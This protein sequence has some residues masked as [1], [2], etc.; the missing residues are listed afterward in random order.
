MSYATPEDLTQ[1]GL[2]A[3][4]LERF[5]WE[6]QQAALEAA[7]ATVEGYLRCKYQVPLVQWGL[8]IRRVVCVLAAY[9]LM[10]TLG[11]NPEGSDTHLRLRTEDALRWLK[12]VSEGVVTLQ[13]DSH[14]A[15]PVP[16]VQSGRL[17]GW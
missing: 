13:V 17:R 6:Q 3:A 4:V 15:R 14:T 9:D 5:P 16:R 2:P 7:S 8:D 12:Q 10:T 11:Y 1:H